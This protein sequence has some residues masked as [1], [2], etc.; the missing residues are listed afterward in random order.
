MTESQSTPTMLTPVELGKTYI[1]FNADGSI[2]N[3]YF[4]PEKLEI[5]E[6]DELVSQLKTIKDCNNVRDIEDNASLIFS[7]WFLSVSDIDIIDQ[8]KS[9]IRCQV[10]QTTIDEDTGK[11]ACIIRHFIE[12]IA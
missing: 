4:V 2:D 11:V 8:E 6:S 7:K 12:N 1:F 3:A 5:N 9:K 10:I